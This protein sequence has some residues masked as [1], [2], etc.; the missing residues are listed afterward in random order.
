MVESTV[1]PAARSA[2]SLLL[3]ALLASLGAAVGQ[4][5]ARFGY[6][7]LLP[8]MRDELG[9]TYAQAG[10]VNSAN[11][12][13]YLAGALAVG[14]VVARWGAPRVIRVSMLALSLSLVSTGLFARFEWLLLARAV[15]G[16]ATGLVFVGGVAVVLALDSSHRSDLP[17]GVYYA[18][19]GIGIALS[20]LLVP[21]MFGLLGWSWHEVWVALGVIGLAAMLLVEAPLRQPGPATLPAPDGVRRLFVWSDYLRL[22][23][24]LTAYTLFGLGYIGYMTFVIAFLRAIGVTSEIVQAFWIVLGLCAASCGFT[25]RPAI[26]RLTPRIALFCI[27]LALAIGAALP[28]LSHSLVGFFVSAM[29]FGSSFLVVVTVITIQVRQA[30]PAERWTTVMGNATALFAFGQLV[31]PT[32]TGLIADMQG[33]LG[34]GLLGSA[35]LLGLAAVIA[36][37]G[38][39]R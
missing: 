27:L 38:G 5:F 39:T 22:W 16:F 1:P 23:P 7:L 30:L 29:L 8:P 2:T 26:R 21:L 18:G 13:G 19:P 37:V 20:G 28:M 15:S 25:W 3:L 31:G 4:G 6:A 12:V 36:L 10:M 24:V 17:I 34:L 14:P 9:W 11:A 35:A 33:G 32:L